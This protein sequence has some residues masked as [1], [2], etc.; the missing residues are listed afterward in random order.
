VEEGSGRNS[1]RSPALCLAE[2]ASAVLRRPG[3]TPLEAGEIISTG[4]LTGAQPIA[5]GE[6]WKV[7]IEGMP[8]PDLQMTFV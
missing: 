6:Q 8:L 3:A 4:T 2:L 1:L 5:A 7:A